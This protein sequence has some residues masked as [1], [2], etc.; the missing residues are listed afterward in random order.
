MNSLPDDRPR[1]WEALCCASLAALDTLRGSLADLMDSVAEQSARFGCE[2]QQVPLAFLSK[3]VQ[4]RALARLRARL[5]AAFQT[6]TQC[7]SVGDA[8]QR[9]INLLEFKSLQFA[10]ALNYMVYKL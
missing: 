10:F 3:H 2:R 8:T 9:S 4:R 7:A 1:N 6:E 5:V